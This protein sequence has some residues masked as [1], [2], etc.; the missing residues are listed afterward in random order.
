MTKGENLQSLREQLDEVD[1]GIVSLYQKRMRLCGE[2]AE[3]KLRSGRAVYDPSREEEKLESVES[4]MNTDFEKKAVRELYRQMMT[5]SRRLQLT[6][7]REHGRALDTGFRKVSSLPFDG[8]KVSYQGT[9][10]AYSCLAAHQAFLSAS[11]ISGYETFR[12]TAEAVRKDKA[13]F[14]VLPIENSTEGPVYHNLD[15]L[16]EFEDLSVVSEI[17]LPVEHALLAVSGAELCGIRRVYSHPQALAQC[18]A[19]FQQHPDI[20]PVPALNTASAAKRVAERDNPEEAALASEAAGRLY[21]LTPLLPAVNQERDNTTRFWIVG[22]ER[23][24]T[25]RARKTSL[26]FELRHHPGRLYTALGSFFF[27]DVNLSMIESRPLPGRQFEY[28]FFVDLE[29]SLADTNILNALNGLAD[30]VQRFRILGC[31]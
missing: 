10:G 16:N 12:E 5:V 7:L 2:V 18:A 21:G 25:D 15:L 26:F 29:G 9:E 13:D 4:M 23:I 8:A 22:R 14:A 31:Y 28:G 20:T 30:S 11:S 3:S 17:R 24:F 6:I 1:R 19:F 27:N